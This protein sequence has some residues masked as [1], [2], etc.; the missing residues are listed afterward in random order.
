MTVRLSNSSLT[1]TERTLV[2]VGTARLASMLATVRAAAPRRTTFSTSPGPAGWRGGLAAAWACR[3]GGRAWPGRGGRACRRERGRRPRLGRRLDGLDRGGGSGA[4]SSGAGGGRLGL[5]RRRSRGLGRRRR[6]R[7]RAAGA[8]AAVAAVPLS[9]ARAAETRAVAG[10]EEGDPGVRPP[11]TGPPGIV[12]TSPRR[13]TGSCR[14]QGLNGLV[15]TRP[16]PRSPLP[17]SVLARR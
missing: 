9:A 14:N 11:R 1:G 16:Q 8:P 10:L 5:G 17:I 3:L 6:R 4:R 2:A 15:R 12:R 7:R 13:A